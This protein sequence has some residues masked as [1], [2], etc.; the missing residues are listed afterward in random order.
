MLRLPHGGDALRRCSK[1]LEGLWLDLWHAPA[2]PIS[3]HPCIAALLHNRPMQPPRLLTLRA[4]SLAAVELLLTVS[5]NWPAVVW[6]T[7][8]R[9]RL[10]RPVTAR[11]AAADSW[12][13]VMLAPPCAC[14]GPVTVRRPVTVRFCRRR[15]W[16]SRSCS[17]L[18]VKYRV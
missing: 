7:V 16:E 5:A 3:T 8:V 18:Y 13:P 1:L 14:S 12:P 4:P 11:P 2:A 6:F 9:C 15:R 10:V 17:T